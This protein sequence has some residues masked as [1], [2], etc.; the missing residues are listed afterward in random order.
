MKITISINIINRIIITVKLRNLIS[1]GRNIG[2]NIPLD[3]SCCNQSIDDFA[4]YTLY[5]AKLED[6]KVTYV[7]KGSRGTKDITW[8]SQR[9]FNVGLDMGFLNGRI[10]ATMDAFF[11]KNKDL[12]M[13]RSLPLTSGFSSA[14][15]NIGAIE[16]KGIEFA[17]E[18]PK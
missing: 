18:I 14:I 11:I 7:P 12:L 3:I 1:I 16:N 15:E 5:D 13:T 17:S 6:G 2:R 4:F 8:E 9:Q 10:T